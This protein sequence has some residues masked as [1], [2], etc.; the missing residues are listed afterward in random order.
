MTL[1]FFARTGEDCIFISNLIAGFDDALGPVGI[2]L[3]SL[4]FSEA[5]S[6][7]APSYMF[8]DVPTELPESSDV[9]PPD[10]PVSLAGAGSRSLG[11]TPP[12]EPLFG[13]QDRF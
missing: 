2:G 13:V 8:L 7:L 10:S 1:G 12:L 9:L 6:D 3:A 11:A 5:F 4:G